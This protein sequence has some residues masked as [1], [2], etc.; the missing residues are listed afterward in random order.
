[1]LIFSVANANQYIINPVKTYVIKPA[2]RGA[3]IGG[4]TGAVSAL[5]ISAHARSDDPCSIYMGAGFGMAELSG[6]QGMLVGGVY[7]T[8]DPIIARCLNLN[9]EQEA[10]DARTRNVVSIITYF[11]S[12]TAK[13]AKRFYP[14][15]LAGEQA[16]FGAEIAAVLPNVPNGNVTNPYSF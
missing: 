8:I 2:Q 15:W 13:C 14:E 3:G 1:M 7:Q 9:R 12:I 4:I 16:R 11:T 6:F 10:V 5:V